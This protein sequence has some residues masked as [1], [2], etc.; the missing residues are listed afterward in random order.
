[1]HTIVV[2]RAI[3]LLNHQWDAKYG[4]G[5]PANVKSLVYT[6]IDGEVELVTTVTPELVLTLNQSFTGSQKKEEVQMAD[7][8]YARVKELCE[9]FDKPFNDES[10][11]AVL[12]SLV[13]VLTYT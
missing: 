10:D 2:N 7:V 13:G 6:N 8:T 9:Q 5:F 11:E 3:T 4:L 12:E 1:V